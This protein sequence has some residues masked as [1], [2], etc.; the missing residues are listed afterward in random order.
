MWSLNLT[1]NHSIVIYISRTCRWTPHLPHLGKYWGSYACLNLHN[2][3][4][5]SQ[6]TSVQGVVPGQRPT[7]I[8]TWFSSLTPMIEMFL[9]IL[10]S[11]CHKLLIAHGLSLVTPSLCQWEAFLTLKALTH[12]R[13]THALSPTSSQVPG[14][15]PGSPL[16]PWCFKHSSWRGVQQC[17]IPFGNWPR[18]RYSFTII[19]KFVLMK[20]QQVMKKSAVRPSGHGFFPFPS[21]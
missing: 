3:G 5:H 10:E 21:A 8:A 12:T 11:T 17:V 9:S 2:P 16:Y 20:L 15:T 18:L 1:N 6:A 13:I 14:V 19:M 4:S 7:Q